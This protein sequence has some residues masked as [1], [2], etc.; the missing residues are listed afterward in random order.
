MKK[1]L[2]VALL[3]AG[4]GLLFVLFT[5]PL[6]QHFT[7]SFLA[8][9]RHDSYQFFWNAWH[10]REAVQSGQNPF[11]TNWILYPQGS[12]L[13]MHAYT[14][15]LGA[16]SVVLGNDMLAVNTGLLLSYALSGTGAYLL[17]R[18]W[19]CSP[20][21]CLLAGFIFAYSPYKLQRLPEHYNLVLTATVPFY[22]LLFLRAFEFREGR[23]LPLVRSWMAVAGCFGLG[24]LTLLS[25]YY[26][27]FGLLYFSLLYVAWFWLRIGRIRWGTWRPWA[28]LAGILVVSHIA[29][30][31][32]RLAGINENGG[33][34]WGGDVVSYLMPPPTSRFVY[35][36]W[37]ARL[38]TNAKVFN[39]PGSL[40]NTVFIGYALPLLA[41]G[42][43][44]LRLTGKRPASRRFQE[45]GGR[46]LAWVLI[47]F[48][49]FTVPTLRIYGHERLNL[50]TAFL[51]FIP[52]FNNI[53]C[54]TRWSMMIGLLLPIVSLSA[55][56]AA[57]HLRLRPV[58][59]TTLSLLLLVVVGI[60]FW[61]KPYQRASQAS[62]PAVYQQ[63]AKLPGTSLIPI[64]LG[65]L[66]GYH[67]VGHLETEQMFY[68]TLHRKKLPIGYLSRVR[69]ELF[70]SMRQEP[71]LRAIL[72]QQ[73]KPDTVQPAPP[74][75][76]QVQAFL[77]TY[78][79]AA[80]VVGPAYRNQPVHAFLRRLL[81]PYGFREHLVD[82]YVLL[83][84]P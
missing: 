8:L 11:F 70:A 6:A 22:I 16:L 79:P 56:E 12:G 42:L 3:L 40:E 20:L 75:A 48:L 61:P 30:R 9:P 2:R 13:V 25:D 77:K 82:G 18:G 31:L 10:F 45:A 33:L 78:D 14:P 63:V 34:W 57:W 39:M 83:A 53:R 74:T 66:D 37:A 5:W 38:Y 81:Q 19:V 68:Q 23:F 54:P 49:L 51:H 59:Q 1:W 47:V 41:L 60:E 27:L 64:P 84:A 28:W 43:W 44:A 35:W 72:Y 4:Y 15:I 17:A 26:V 76:P 80:F 55:L 69:P 24:V 52:F 73:T 7:S 36:D 71:V 21:L 46:P 32:L 65:I 58:V 50:P 62:I 29:I 67:Q